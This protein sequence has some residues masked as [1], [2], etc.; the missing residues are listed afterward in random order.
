MCIDIF[1]KYKGGDYPVRAATSER[2][3]LYVNI[4]GSVR[5]REFGTR[6]EFVTPGSSVHVEA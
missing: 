6:R 4:L 1:Y 2:V 3:V 5:Q